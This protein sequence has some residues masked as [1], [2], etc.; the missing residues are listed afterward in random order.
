MMSTPPPSGA[1][2]AASGI[3][4]VPPY[5]PADNEL[6]FILALQILEAEGLVQE[7]VAAQVEC[8][9]L[10]KVTNS[11]IFVSP[12]DLKVVHE[13]AEAYDVDLRL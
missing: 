13:L 8:I 12:A 1:V 7:H 4:T 5:E 11:R 9:Q 2:A 3:Q 6:A 10:C